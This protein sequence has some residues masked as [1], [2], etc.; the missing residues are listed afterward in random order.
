[1]TSKKKIDSKKA[2]SKKTSS[3]ASEGPSHADEERIA[4]QYLLARVAGDVASGVLVSPSPTATT[5]DRIAEISVDIAEEI[6]KRV[7]L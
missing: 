5:P 6:L 1:M 7:G 2:V 4:R 3:A